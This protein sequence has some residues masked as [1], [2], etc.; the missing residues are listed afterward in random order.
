MLTSKDTIGH[1]VALSFVRPRSETWKIFGIAA[2]TALGQTR[3][4]VRTGTCLELHGL[5]PPSAS[6]LVVPD[7]AAIFKNGFEAKPWAA[8]GKLTVSAVLQWRE[9][10]PFGGAAAKRVGHRSQN[11]LPFSFRAAASV[12]GFMPD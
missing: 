6:A 2:T 9:A 12:R 8:N 7:D 1:D 11:A 3:G 5:P 10:W 4:N